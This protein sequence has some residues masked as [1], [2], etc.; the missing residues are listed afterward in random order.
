MKIEA[1]LVD[2]DTQ[3]IYPASIT[4][5]DSHIVSIKR[6]NEVYNTFILPGFI[7]AH[8]HIESS[9]LV[10]SEFARLAV[11]HGTVATVSDPHEIANVLGVKGI[12]YMIKNAKESGFKCYF[13]ASPC[14]PATPF[15][16]N[17][18]I[19]SPKEIEELLKQDD[20]Y[21]LSEVMNFPGVINNDSDMMAKIALAKKYNKPID[22]HAPA[23]SGKELQKYLDV[24]ITTDHEAFTYEEAKEKLQKGMKIQIREGSAAKNYEALHLLIEEY[25]ENM[26]FCSDDKHPNDLLKGHI[27]ELVKQALKDGHDLFKV[28]CIASK[29]PVEHYGLDVGLLRVGDKADFIEV[30]DLKNFEILRT[31]IDGK[32]V[33]ASGQIY[34]PRVKSL[35][36]N[37][38]HTSKKEIRAFEIEAKGKEYRIID[39]LNNQLI[40]KE[41][42]QY[43]QSKNGVVECDIQKD[44]L[45]ISVTNRY[46]DVSPAVSFVHGF[47]LKEGAIASS[48]AHDSHNIIA[49]GCDAK[50]MALAVNAVIESKGGICVVDSKE[51]I[52]L[53]SLPIAG[54]MSDNSGEKVAKR[55]EEIENIVKNK[56]GSTLDAPFMTLSFM[57]LLVIP[58]IK[59]SDKGL[60]DT[61]SFHFI[62]ECIL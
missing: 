49:V 17:G 39:A 5:K 7:D 6:S 46:E 15:E 25:F 10:P 27:K 19:L 34:L 28:L 53:L 37:N 35:H 32:E 38:F 45:L 30:K 12:E 20:I 31:F 3:E 48:V 40:T 4:I 22:G 8:I 61:N 13:G 57:A 51:K 60:F 44:Y 2:I 62:G 21:Y 41:E 52:E 24:G 59:L 54:L 26:M 11:R 16:T 58:D 47:G 9:M 55:Y 33:Y 29:N 23:L 56:L 18:A 42:H 14:V 43:L 50:S 36:V 1:N